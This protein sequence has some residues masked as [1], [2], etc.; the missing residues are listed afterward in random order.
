M[1]A[2]ARA[3]RLYDIEARLQDRKPFPF[4]R[5]VPTKEVPAGEPL[6]DLWVRIRVD[7]TLVVRAIEAASDTTPWDLCRQAEA[8]LAV[9]V[10]ERI[11]RGWSSRV[12]EKLRGAAGCTHLTE[13][14][15]PM[16]T[17]ALQGIRGVNR[18]MIDAVDAAGAPQALDSC[19]SYDRRREVVKMLW[20][21]HHVAGDG[22]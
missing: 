2:F 16:A 11:G 7:R 5:R 21:R 22:A 9:L 13:M 12:K 14:L 20:P 17:V 18:E 15:I 19:F 4:R 10:G 3:D 1:R 8:T 6:H